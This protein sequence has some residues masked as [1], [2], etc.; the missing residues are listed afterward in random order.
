MDLSTLSIH[1]ATSVKALE[2]TSG[3]VKVVVTDAEGGTFE[4]NIWPDVADTGP[5][6]LHAED[7]A[8]VAKVAA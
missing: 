8:S 5:L 2:I 1:G 4:V 6:K 7:I 3:G